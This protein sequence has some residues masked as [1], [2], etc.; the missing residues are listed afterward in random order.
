MDSPAHGRIQ[1][2][3]AAAMSGVLRFVSIAGFALLVLLIILIIIS[4]TG[5][6]EHSLSNPPT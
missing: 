1:S 2:D 6:F 3:G 4:F 5:G